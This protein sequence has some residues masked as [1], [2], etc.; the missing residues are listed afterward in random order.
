MYFAHQTF[1]LATDLFIGIGL[2]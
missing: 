1:K 2:R